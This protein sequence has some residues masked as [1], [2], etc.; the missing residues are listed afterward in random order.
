MS[1]LPS[2]FRSAIDDLIAA[3]QA[4][5]DFVRDELG[6]AGGRRLR[7]HERPR[8]DLNGD[9]GD[10]RRA[11]AGNGRAFETSCGLLAVMLTSARSHAAPYRVSPGHQRR[12]PHRDDGA[13]AQG[14][15][16][17]GPEGRRDV[18]RQRQRH[19]HVA[20][21]PTCAALEKKIEAR[22]RAGA[23]LRGARRSSGPA[24][25]SRRSPATSRSRRRRSSDD[26]TV[27]VG[28]VERPL[29]AAD[30]RA[31]MTFK[32]E[33]D[34]F[35]VKGREVYWLR[36]TRQSRIAVQVRQ[37]GKEA[38]DPRDVPRHQHRGA[39]GRQARSVMILYDH[40]AHDRPHHDPRPARPARRGPGGRRACAR[41]I[42]AG[43][44]ERR[45]HRHPQHAGRP[46]ASTRPASP[47]SRRAT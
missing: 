20:R 19:L 1:G 42:R 29:D 6:G 17:A 32:T 2:L 37:P 9:Q 13:A 27:Y 31:V 36:K 3:A 38:E 11:A 47:R 34:D 39:A 15:R 5:A 21:R 22:L 28:F 41:P 46:G 43:V 44:R 23:R 14:V 8:D 35:R 18:H 16:G 24:P 33:V 26:A 25:R 45:A 4:G 30:T 12:R 10:Q 40:D 7:V